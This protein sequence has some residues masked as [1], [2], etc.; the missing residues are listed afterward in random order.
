VEGRG[1]GGKRA[2]RRPEE[3]VGVWG[4][5]KNKVQGSMRH[6]WKVENKGG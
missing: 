1:K 5:V 6:R 4:V 3:G 2:K